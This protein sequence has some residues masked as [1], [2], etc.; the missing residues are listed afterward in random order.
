M[1]ILSYNSNSSFIKTSN[2][3][4]WPSSCNPWETAFYHFGFALL[5]WNTRTHSGQQ[6]LLFQQC[7]VWISCGYWSTDSFP[8]KWTASF[9][10]ERNVLDKGWQSYEASLLF[11]IIS[12]SLY[13]QSILWLEY[14]R[15]SH[16]QNCMYLRGFILR[17]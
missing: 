10:P 8:A 4:Y 14:E 16:T 6:V 13:A 17:G 3:T 2:W 7:K 12:F 1:Q 5:S 9:H 15:Y 11:V